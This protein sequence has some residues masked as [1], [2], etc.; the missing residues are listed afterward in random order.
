MSNALRAL[1]LMQIALNSA[2]NGLSRKANEK[3][4]TFSIKLK[5]INEKE[6]FVTQH[7]ELYNYHGLFFLS[8]AAKQSTTTTK[9]ILLEAARSRKQ[10]V[11]LEVRT[12]ITI[13]T[14]MEVAFFVCN[15][16][17]IK[18]QNVY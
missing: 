17:L 11:A 13:Y 15:S 9:L 18:I 5:L 3:K 7:L 12:R 2:L 8:F 14:R 4:K 10:F 16:N 1:I 6:S